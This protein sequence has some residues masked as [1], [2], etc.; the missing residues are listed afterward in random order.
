MNHSADLDSNI[1]QEPT[2]GPWALFVVLEYC[3][4]HGTLEGAGELQLSGKP[5]MATRVGDLA[6]PKGSL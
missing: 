4:V 1:H 5:G 6:C 3:C 2:R